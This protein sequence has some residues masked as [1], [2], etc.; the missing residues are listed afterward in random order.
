MR[1]IVGAGREEGGGVGAEK[2]KFLISA[3]AQK[4]VSW[5]DQ[6][7]SSKFWEQSFRAK[8]LLWTKKE[9][10]RRRQKTVKN[11]KK[12]W[13]MRK[14]KEEWWHLLIGGRTHYALTPHRTPSQSCDRGGRAETT[15]LHSACSLVGQRRREGV[16]N[17]ESARTLSL[18][19]GRDEIDRDR[20]K[21]WEL[22][23]G[24]RYWL[25]AFD[26][27]NFN[28]YLHIRGMRR[29]IRYFGQISWRCMWVGSLALCR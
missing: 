10:L 2:R 17:E 13:R 23:S 5:F 25:D 26:S 15:S 1:L 19:H 28:A 27:Q 11:D 9:L 8:I 22:K 14:R 24:W 20:K 18:V 12:W 6:N 4:K 21:N 16:R 7:Y 29:G 3:R